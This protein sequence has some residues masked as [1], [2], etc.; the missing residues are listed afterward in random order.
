MASLKS[1]AGSAATTG[2]SG[3]SRR[4]SSAAEAASLRAALAGMSG[5]QRALFWKGVAKLLW[6]RCM[7]QRARNLELRREL[8]GR[9]R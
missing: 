9:R 8:E 6:D 5:E 4:V 1:S 3:R 7:A 2:R